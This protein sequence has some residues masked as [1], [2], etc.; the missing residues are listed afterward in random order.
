MKQVVIKVY[1]SLLD[2]GLCNPSSLSLHNELLVALHVP[3]SSPHHCRT[4]GF[5]IKEPETSLVVRQLYNVTLQ[6]HIMMHPGEGSLK[7]MNGHRLS[8]SCS[9]FFVLE[10]Q[11][12]SGRLLGHFVLPYWQVTYNQKTVYWL[13]TNTIYIP[14]RKCSLHKHTSHCNTIYSVPVCIYI[15]TWIVQNNDCL[16]TCLCQ[17][18]LD[19][20]FT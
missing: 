19:S 17:I 20:Y 5:T 12:S 9:W 15:H 1:N 2:A 8:R 16:L 6:D 10:L 4:L 3:S 13:A 11:T 18:N 7:S 14:L